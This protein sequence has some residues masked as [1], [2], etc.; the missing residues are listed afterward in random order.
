M[1]SDSTLGIPDA[2]LDRL[3]TLSTRDL[4]ADPT[5]REMLSSLDCDLLEATLPEARAAL[6][7]NLPAI[8]ERVVAEWALDRNP[9]SAYTLGN[10][11]VAFA[12]QPDHIEQLIHF[13]D[14]MPSQLFRDVLPEIVSLFNEMPRGAEAWKYAITVLGLVLASRS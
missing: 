1:L 8:A 14:R 7:N 9:M 6:E 12:R 3:A 4:L 13:H 10:W 11:V 5:Y 2:S